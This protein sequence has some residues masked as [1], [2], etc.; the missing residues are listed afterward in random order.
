[1]KPAHGLYI[2]LF[3]VAVVLTGTS[4]LPIGNFFSTVLLSIGCGGI[5]SVIIAWLVDI[6]NY[7]LTRKENE[8]KFSLIM[9]ECVHLYKDLLFVAV[10]ECH[11]LYHDK[12][13]RTFKAW[14]DIL[15]DNA[16]CHCRTNDTMDRRFQCLS[17]RIS[18]IQNFIE[19]FR[20]QSVTLILNGYPNIKNILNFFEMQNVHCWGT[21]NQL[22]MKNYKAFCDT[23]NI[24]Y[25][26][27]TE[28]FPEYTKEIP[29]QYNMEIA[30]KWDE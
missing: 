13:K 14:L 22:N 10:N 17:A 9:E 23:T 26:E 24:L 2:K 27:F 6:R 28:M 20:S 16:N 4:L 8:Y 3:I 5:A 30:R 29:E 21:L 19:R 1:M 15:G 18:A 12:E 7:R 25:K 11:G